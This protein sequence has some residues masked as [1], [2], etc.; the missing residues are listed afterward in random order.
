FE[1][2]DGQN[3]VFEEVYQTT[4]SVKGAESK[5]AIL[6]IDG[7]DY[8]RHD[9]AINEDFI[10]SFNLHNIG[11]SKAHNIKISLEADKEIIPKSTSIRTISSLDINAIEKLSFTLSSTPEAVTKNYPIAI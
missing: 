11:S 4:L 2:K 6:S 5:N 8:P 10:I 9:L 3:Q 1:Y 7:I